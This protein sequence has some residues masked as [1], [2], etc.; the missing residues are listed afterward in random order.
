MY[1]E[2]EEPVDTPLGDWQTEAK[3]LVRI[4]PCGQALCGYVLDRST[5]TK[6]ETV[7]VDMKSKTDSEWSGNIYSRDTGSTYYATMALK[8]PNSLRVEACALGRFFCSGN[9]WSRIGAT[10]A[11]LVTYRQALAEP[12]SQ[13]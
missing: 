4:E 5:N 10:P 1:R 7:L 11:R 3:G 6:R 9:A 13:N 2:P 8:G 12:R